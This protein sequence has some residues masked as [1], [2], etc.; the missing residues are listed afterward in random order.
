MKFK[1]FFKDLKGNNFNLFVS[2]IDGVW[3]IDIYFVMRGLISYFY[4]FVKRFV[5][6]VVISIS[7]EDVGSKEIRY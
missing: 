6:Y 4:W 7:S 2:G 5:F 1:V 3:E